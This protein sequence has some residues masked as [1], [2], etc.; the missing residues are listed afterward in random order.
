M[1]KTEKRKLQKERA[2]ARAAAGLPKLP[3]WRRS[4]FKAGEIQS[5]M[6]LE[7]TEKHRQML[8]QKAKMRDPELG[9]RESD[10][11]AWKAAAHA[12][13]EGAPCNR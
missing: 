8:A 2:T 12:T 4:I 6:Q 13:P 10:Y 7:I 11:Q 3:P 1:T 5:A 9:W